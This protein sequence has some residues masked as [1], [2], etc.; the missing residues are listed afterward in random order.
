MI[1][2]EPLWRFD[3]LYADRRGKSH[4]K[5]AAVEVKGK[6]VSSPRHAE[7]IFDTYIRP[8]KRHALIERWN[9]SLRWSENKSAEFNA[10]PVL[11][12]PSTRCVRPCQQRLHLE[13]IRYLHLLADGTL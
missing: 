2:I 8:I 12:V 1:Q 7:P 4:Q 11:M 3:V 5:V 10:C 9:E 13:Y 6:I